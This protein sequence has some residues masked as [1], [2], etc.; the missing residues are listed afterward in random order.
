[1][2]TGF[3]TFRSVTFAQRGE[4]VLRRGNIGCSLQRTPRWME[5]QGCGYCLRLKLADAKEALRLLR[6]QQVDF[7]KVY[8]RKEDGSVEEMVP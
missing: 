6:Q 3:I 7:R 4:T 2:M 8:R 5:E 1:M